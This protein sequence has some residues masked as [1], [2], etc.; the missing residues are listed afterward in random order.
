MRT[1]HSIHQVGEKNRIWSFCDTELF[2]TKAL[3]RIVR[4]TVQL[5]D[6]GRIYPVWMGK[7][8]HFLLLLTRA[9]PAVHILLARFLFEEPIALCKIKMD[10]LTFQSL[11]RP[12]TELKA[13][14]FPLGSPGN[15]VING[16]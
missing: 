1:S 2:N 4:R 13:F 9:V 8:Q 5:F 12:G 3:R 15:G 10:I 6:Y 7:H 16:C 14:L 11:K